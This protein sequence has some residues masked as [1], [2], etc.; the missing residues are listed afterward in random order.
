MGSV[1]GRCEGL[2]RPVCTDGGPSTGLSAPSDEPCSRRLLS[3]LRASI[4]CTK[5]EMSSS[6]VLVLRYDTC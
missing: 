4:C 3:G 2:S 1:V 5:S 6:S